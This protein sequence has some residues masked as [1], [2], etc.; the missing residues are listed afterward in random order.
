MKQWNGKSTQMPRYKKLAV[1]FTSVNYLRMNNPYMSIWWGMAFPGFGQWFQGRY[2]Y[3]LVLILW[4]FFINV[5][6]HL[7]V[8]IFF[9]M[10]GR[11]DAAKASLDQRWFLM[12]IAIYLYC[13]WDGYHVGTQM[14]QITLLADRERQQLRSY[15]ISS[16][17]IAFHTLRNPRTAAYWSLLLPG[18]GHFLLQRKLLA[19]FFIL[20]WTITMYYSRV[21][22]GV[23]ASLIGD[24][25]TVRRVIDPQWLLFVPSLYMFACY[26]SY[27]STCRLNELYMEEL[28]GHLLRRWSPREGRI[29]FR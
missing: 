11:I 8:A 16:I 5:K 6:S 20:C 2:V 26:D 28:R 27:V 12:Y 22:Q 21:P 3:G 17:T 7:N 9:T 10:I 19:I 29:S 13:A 25:Q 24:F 14:N 23:I 1:S 15:Y 18:S 4:E